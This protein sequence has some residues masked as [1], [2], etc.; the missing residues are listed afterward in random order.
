MNMLYAWIYIHLLSSIVQ[1][2]LVYKKWN[3]DIL[4]KYEHLNMY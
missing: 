3:N 1:Y 4:I 2:E